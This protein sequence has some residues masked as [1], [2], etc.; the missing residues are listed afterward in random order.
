MKKA[1]FILVTTVGLSL[2]GCGPNESHTEAQRKELNPPSTEYTA[3]PTAPA[4]E[5]ESKA[6][7]A[8]QLAEIQ[9]AE[10]KSRGL[11][12]NDLLEKFDYP[13][14]IGARYFSECSSF[15]S[16]KPEIQAHEVCNEVR[17]DNCPYSEGKSCGVDGEFVNG[18][19]RKAS[20]NY[21]YG[22]FDGDALKERLDAEYG[23]VPVEEKSL[24]EFPMKSWSSNWR[25]PSGLAVIVFRTQGVNINGQRYNNV[26]VMF[27]DEKLPDP[28]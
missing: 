9:A 16:K 7:L 13:I 14:I 23:K 3:T 18:E 20:F 6:K 28:Y 17:I 24:P 21:E 10:R 12:V 8:Q 2:S 19:L 11:G 22:K 25:L 27:I 1:A 15:R 26:S 4:L 5:A